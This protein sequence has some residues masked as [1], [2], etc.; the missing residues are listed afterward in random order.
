MK[1]E[2]ERLTIKEYE[3]E[4]WLD[5]GARLKMAEAILRDL[6]LDISHSLG[7]DEIESETLADAHIHLDRARDM[8]FD[9]C[10][11]SYHPI[12]RDVI[13][14]MFYGE[15]FANQEEYVRKFIKDF[16]KDYKN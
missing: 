3:L 6:M 10:V 5:L 12:L 11:S 15:F 13:C 16:V 4:E 7:Y 2:E 9:L 14:K 8:L 1:K